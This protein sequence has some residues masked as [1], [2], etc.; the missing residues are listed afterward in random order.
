MNIKIFI[1]AF[2]ALLFVTSFAK[3]DDLVLKSNTFIPVILQE[4]ISSEDLSLGQDILF[5]VAADVEVSGTTVIESGTTVI[6]TVSDLEE[7]GSIGAA[8]KI[9]IS[10]LNTEAVD[11]TNIPLR[12]TKVIEGEDES[13]STVVVGVV[14]CPLALLNEGEE[15]KVGEGMQARALVAQNTKI[16]F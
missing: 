4:N 1:N 11:G 6:A 15:A 3:A 5:T 12:G 10:F 13:T 9:V 14:L 16:S 7:K 8:G 2:V